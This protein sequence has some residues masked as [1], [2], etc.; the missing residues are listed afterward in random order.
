MP[1]P[2]SSVG[3]EALS[4]ITDHEDRGTAVL[5]GDGAGAVLVGRGEQGLGIGAFDFGYDA[6]SRRCSTPSA[7]SRR[8]AWRARRSTATPLRG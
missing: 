4:R 3:A 6:S 2:C 5:F 8:C 7:T 1:R